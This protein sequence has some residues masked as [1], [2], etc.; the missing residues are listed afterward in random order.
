MRDVAERAGVA[1]STV[2]RALANPDRVSQKTRDRI[3]AAAAQLGY[4]PN[5]VARNLRKGSARLMMI[6]LPGP[7]FSGAS[8]IIPGVLEGVAATLAAEGFNLMIA[9]L[10]RSEA[11][12]RHIL[13]LA[14]GGTIAGSMTLASYLPQ[15]GARSLVGAGLPLVGILQDVSGQGVPSVVTNDRTA[16]RDATARLLALGHRSFLYIA[17][18][19]DNYHEHERF[20]G[21]QAAIAAAGLPPAAVQRIESGDS[22]QF[23]LQAG[24]ATAESYLRIPPAQRPT[25]II[26]SS[27]DAA[28]AFMGYVTRAGVQVPGDVS[29]LGF[30]GA[31]VG[32]HL[33]PPLSSLIQPARA[34]GNE[35]ARLLLAQ[36]SG[37]K[38]PS[39]VTLESTLAERGS[40]GPAPTR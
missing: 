24:A 16:M 39:V 31:T 21:V 33:A 4:T 40:T 10:D 12:E 2:S 9:N 19:P 23:G 38:I 14:Y 35:A 18:P 11:V 36:L 26:A 28:I 32:A 37:A 8:Q 34:M 25:A 6:V 3:I 27:D 1:I 20:G 22:F 17:A 7:F 13:D 5:A 30:D 15:Q 29:V